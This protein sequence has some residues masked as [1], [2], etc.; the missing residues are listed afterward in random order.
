M[1]H[2]ALR[3][4]LGYW[5]VQQRY[6]RYGVEGLERL[7]RPDSVLLVGYHGRPIAYDLCMLSV[8]MY[9][10][11]G[12]L[13]HGIIHKAVR[14]NGALTWLSDGLG[15]VTGDGPEISAAVSRGEHI[16]VQPGGTRE[17]CRSARHRYAVDWGS[18]TGYLRMAIRHG[19]HIVPVASRGVD[20]GYLGLNNGYRWGKRLGAPAGLPVWFGIGLTGLWPLSP[21]F[22]VRITTHIGHDIDVSDVD[23]NDPMAL[24]MAHRHIA[25][26]VQTLV[27]RINA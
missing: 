14:Q 23:P 17:G 20:D 27:H 1:T 16:A 13:P 9:R 24:A 26:E 8:S 18:R 4:W 25:G 6:H 10:R 22:P 12:T 15:F 21:P 19:L 7:D 11:F 2:P 3:L 5:G